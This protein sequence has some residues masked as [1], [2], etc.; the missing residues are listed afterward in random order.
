M[1]LQYR[2]FLKAWSEQ[3]KSVLQVPGYVPHPVDK[4]PRAILSEADL[5]RHVPQPNQQEKGTAMRWFF[6]VNEAKRLKTRCLPE[7]LNLNPKDQEPFTLKTR[8]LPEP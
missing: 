6:D 5:K 1:T 8:C 2:R 4:M 7:P 3:Y